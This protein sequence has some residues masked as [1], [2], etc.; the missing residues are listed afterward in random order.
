[1]NLINRPRR[2]RNGALLRSMVRETRISADTLI[3]PM[4]VQDG[5]NI[6]EEIPSMPGQYRWSLDRVDELLQQ[7]T[8]SGVKSVLLFGIPAEK[9]E[10]GS[11]AWQPDGMCSVQCVISRRHFRSCMSLPMFVCVSIPLTDTAAFSAVTM[12]ITTR[13]WRFWRKRRCPMYRQERIWS[14]RPI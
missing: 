5:E 9:D 14:H 2:L 8:D 7:V 6:R 4:F 12:W 10:I 3:Y 1:M 13:R 11:S